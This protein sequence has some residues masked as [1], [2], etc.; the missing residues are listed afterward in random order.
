MSNEYASLKVV[1]YKNILFMLR[2]I[3]W[4]SS[5]QPPTLLFET[6]DSHSSNCGDDCVLSSSNVQYSRTAS[7]VSLYKHCHVEKIN[8]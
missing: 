3:F 5:S 6:G 8:K 1:A 2:P 4:M 7:Y